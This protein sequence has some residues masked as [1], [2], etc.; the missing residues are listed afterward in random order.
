MASITVFIWARPSGD[1][2]SNGLRAQLCGA[3]RRGV[4][5]VRRGY[6]L[7]SRDCIKTQR[8]D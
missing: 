8:H 5:G 2:M 3:G 4:L 6:V 1:G 7:R